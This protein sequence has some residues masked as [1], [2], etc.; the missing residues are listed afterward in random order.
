MFVLTAILLSL[1]GAA[2][3][4]V[5]RPRVD[6]RTIAVGASNVRYDGTTGLLTVSDDTAAFTYRDSVSSPAHLIYN[7]S[8]AFGGSYTLH[9]LFTGLGAEA[10]LDGMFGSAGTNHPDLVITG[11]IPS[12]GIT[13][14]NDYTGTLLEADVVIGELFGWNASNST[15]EFNLILEV[16]GGDL[17]A[18]GLYSEGLRLGELSSVFTFSPSLPAGFDFTTDFSATFQSAQVGVP[19]PATLALAGMG[20]LGGFAAKRLAGRKRR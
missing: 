14:A 8:G 12:L 4:D 2:G 10:P 9:A 13:L 5:I 15:A 17:V 20:L 11:E 18:A 1:V 3:A 19:E 7:L 16:L 6:R